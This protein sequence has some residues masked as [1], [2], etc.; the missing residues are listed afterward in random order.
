MVIVIES[1]VREWRELTAPHRIRIVAAVTKNLLDRLEGA[2]S[3][4]DRQLED[5]ARAARE[6]AIGM[7]FA[8]DVLDEL[9]LEADDS[10][11][12]E[13]LRASWSSVAPPLHIPPPPIAQG[14]IP[15]RRTALFAAGGALVGMLLLGG[16]TRWL[17]GDA[18]VGMVIGGAL[19][20]GSLV[21]LV[22]HL[23]E[24]PAVRS[25]VA[26]LLGFAGVAEL[27]I[28]LA[29]AGPA[30]LWRRLAAQGFV[31]R[32][33]AYAGI[34]ALLILTR[35]VYR[36]D[37][38]TYLPLVEFSIGQWLDE[39]LLLLYLL[40]RT[41]VPT[42]ALTVLDGEFA[43]AIIELHRS[44]AENLATSAE[45][46]L[47]EAR[48]L[49]LE[50]LAGEPGFVTGRDDEAETFA[51][52]PEHAERY[53]TFGVVEPGDLVIVEEAPIVQNGLVTDK[54]LVRRHRREGSDGR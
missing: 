41:L 2:R 25:R 7:M 31:K 19:G 48:R 39:G 13:A 11:A 34:S 12:R 21:N 37:R 8:D 5:A 29:T 26:K 17:L 22:L 36:F 20:G 10:P 6:Q 30:M 52:Q 32:L 45:G 1:Q 4:D 50:G 15:A 40:D 53:R 23:A 44:R 38:A 46:V 3:P 18:F 51:W 35:Q 28:F 43:R 24:D 47:L 16:L 49:G 33:L 42:R 14:G 9:P 54:G 27:A